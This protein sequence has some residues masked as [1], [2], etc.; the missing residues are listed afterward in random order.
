M[1]AI[2][3]GRDVATA[4][5]RHALFGAAPAGDADYP[6]WGVAGVCTSITPP[7]LANPSDHGRLCAASGQTATHTLSMCCE[8]G[9]RYHAGPGSGTNV[10]STSLA[11]IAAP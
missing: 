3:I 2:K 1:D 6:C 11:K 8:R 9:L 5:W 10:R 7:V 4:R